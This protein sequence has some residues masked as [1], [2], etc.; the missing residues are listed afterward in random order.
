MF[1]KVGR[2]RPRSPKAGS[3]SATAAVPVGTSADRY[4]T[5]FVSYARSDF[6]EVSFFAQGLS[7][8]GITPCVDISTLEPG[9]E[10]EKELQAHI[11]Q[12]DVFYLMWSE[13]AAKSNYVDWETRHA[14]GL[15]QQDQEPKRPRKDSAERKGPLA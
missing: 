10:W 3:S 8:K 6:R 1:A 13:N 12:A 5:A 15:Y 11:D 7:E 14:F 2:Q 4:R 9:E